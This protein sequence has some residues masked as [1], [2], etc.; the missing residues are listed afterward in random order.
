M[1]DID[2]TTAFTPDVCRVRVEGRE[3]VAMRIDPDGR[4][5]WI[6]AGTRRGSWTWEPD[7]KVTVLHRLVPEPEEKTL[8]APTPDWDTLRAAAEIAYREDGHS[9]YYLQQLADRLEAE[10]RATQ[11]KA[12]RE[13][14]AREA[15]IERA[16]WVIQDA[17]CESGMTLIS[18]YRALARALADAGYLAEAVQS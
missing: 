7:T 14:A 15:L 5:P 10:H 13:K 3:T 6:V 12:E 16:A 2:P 1:T 4:E 8:D 18:T 9:L 11:E 17:D